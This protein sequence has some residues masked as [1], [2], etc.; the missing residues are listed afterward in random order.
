M[1]DVVRELRVGYRA[2][3]RQPVLSLVALAAYSRA[4]V[5]ES[6]AAERALAHQRARSAERYVSPLHRAVVHIGLGHADDAMAALEESVRE[7]SFN[8]LWP[9]VNPVF[10][11]VRKTPPFGEL[12]RSANLQ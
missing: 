5:G 10:D 2:L 9:A 3:A 7:R 11:P 12:L 1:S 6:A 8:L 4:R